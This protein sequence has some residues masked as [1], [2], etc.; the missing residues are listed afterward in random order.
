MV[1]GGSMGA[2]TND[3]KFWQTTPSPY[4]TSVKVSKIDEDNFEDPGKVFPIRNIGRSKWT[5]ILYGHTS[6]GANST[7]GLE[8]D[9]FVD[10]DCGDTP[11]ERVQ[12]KLKGNSNFYEGQVPNPTGYNDN[13]RFKDKDC[14]G[15]NDDTDLCE[16]V[17]HII[18]TFRVHHPLGC[19]IQSN[20]TARNLTAQWNSG[21]EFGGA[22]DDQLRTKKGPETSSPGR[23]LLEDTYRVTAKR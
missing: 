13:K 2:Y 22:T 7:N 17:S 5:M 14:R 1:R 15:V 23:C 20:S 12:L 9:H 18:L 4:C 16:H 8:L 19:P 10:G 11:G 21:R 6:N 3:P